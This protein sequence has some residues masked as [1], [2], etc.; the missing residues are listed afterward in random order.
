M[1]FKAIAAAVLSLAAGASMAQ[2]LT[3][4]GVASGDITGWLSSDPYISGLS[5]TQPIFGSTAAGDYAF[6]E[7]PASIDLS[8]VLPNS[9]APP[10]WY[11]LVKVDPSKSVTPS[12]SAYASLTPD[13]GY[14][15]SNGATSINTDTANAPYWQVATNYGSNVAS[16]YT[17]ITPGVVLNAPPAT[18]WI[19]VPESAPGTIGG[20]N[21]AIFAVQISAVPEP[22]AYAMA[23][24]GLSVL[25]FIGRRRKAV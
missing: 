24:A 2:T 13:S 21:F 8:L 4:N 17:Q 10:S 23:L 15:F 25:G 1:K 16:P 18:S 22:G 5:P 20:E 19:G 11:L 9:S 6:L 3:F 7:A 12:L 14:V